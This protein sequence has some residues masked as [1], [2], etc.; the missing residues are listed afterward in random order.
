M[1][2]SC[3]KCDVKIEITRDYEICSCGYIIN[4]EVK[5]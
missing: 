2:V 3:D 4:Q 1:I 5:K